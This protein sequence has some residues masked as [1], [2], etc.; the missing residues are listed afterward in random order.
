MCGNGAQAFA[1]LTFSFIF[2]ARSRPVFLAIIVFIVS[3]E[4]TYLV[5][6]GAMLRNL[7]RVCVE[8]ER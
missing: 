4:Y 1:L 8:S 3:S 5:F 6:C 7:N 2:F